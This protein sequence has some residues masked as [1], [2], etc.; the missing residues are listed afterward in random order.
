MIFINYSLKKELFL[1]RKK[2]SLF[3]F[4]KYK[5][6]IIISYSSS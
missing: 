1:N 3:D 4:F 5:F 2:T 6:A